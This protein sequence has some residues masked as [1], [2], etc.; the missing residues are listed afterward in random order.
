MS[1]KLLSISQT[2]QAVA[3]KI[4][5]TKNLQT[6][7]SAA[8]NNCQRIDD[9]NK[10]IDYKIKFINLNDFFEIYK[11]KYAALRRK[12]KPVEAKKRKSIFNE[13]PDDIVSRFRHKGIMTLRTESVNAIQNEKLTTKSNEIDEITR[14]WKNKMIK[15]L[16]NEKP[17]LSNDEAK[18]NNIKYKFS[19]ENK[20]HSNYSEEILNNLNGTSSETENNERFKF[21]RYVNGEIDSLTQNI[22]VLDLS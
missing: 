6:R 18:I 1:E 14:N 3:D 10:L 22:I 8:I 12:Y 19:N 15:W 4:S 16:S 7:L 5:L 11:L 20:E 21:M 2:K 13:N 9:I 17:K